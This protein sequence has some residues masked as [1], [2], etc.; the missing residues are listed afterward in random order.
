MDN[1]LSTHQ[2]LDNLNVQYF[3]GDYTKCWD[4]W[5]Y[6]NVKPGYNK[7]YYIVDGE[8]YIKIDDKEYVA[9]KGMLFLLPYNSTQTYHHISEN[10]VTKYWFHFTLSCNDKDLLE[11][12]TLPHYIDVQEPKKV[13]DLF[14]KIINLDEE[15]TIQAKLM[16][17]SYIM[18]LFAYYYEHASNKQDRI[19]KDDKIATI[20]SYIEN[21]LNQDLNVPDLSNILHLHPN[22]FIHYFKNMVG[23]PPMEYINNL[24]IERAKKLLQSENISIGDIA[25]QIGF[26]S[27]YYFSRIFK[28]KTGFTPS[29]YR[30]IA[31][32][33]PKK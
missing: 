23:K 21:N 31:H 9:S 7:F 6:E 1:N 27:S 33:K 24:R 10:Y 30:L 13:R 14:T 2:Y 29:D 4:I 11:L 32:A 18:Q 25:V 19:F 8:C 16:Q 3:T 5:R 22:Y 12:I 28:K 15:T 20:L 26:T 17:K